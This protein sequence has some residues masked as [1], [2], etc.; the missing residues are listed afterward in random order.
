[1]DFLDFLDFLV[2]FE[3]LG[4]AAALDASMGAGRRDL[5]RWGLAASGGTC[6]VASVNVLERDCGC[7]CR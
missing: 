2:N 3:P 7:S 1:M 5:E 4:F 6:L